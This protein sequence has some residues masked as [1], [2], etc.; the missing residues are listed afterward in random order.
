M[1]KFIGQYKEFNPNKDYPSVTNYF[2]E[3]PYEGK[4]KI[5]SFLKLS[6]KPG[7]LCASIP[8]DVVTGKTIPISNYIMDGEKYSWPL[9]LAY[10]VD[11]YNM[12]L[13]KEFEDEILNES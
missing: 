7:L 9:I 8:H 10:Y 1:R 2:S 12:R 6:G 4:G 11:K 5:V 3:T 13:P